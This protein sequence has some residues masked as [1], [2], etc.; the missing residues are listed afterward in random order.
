M[1]WV[2]DN[3]PT[4]SELQNGGTT[5]PFVGR[6]ASQV[7]DPSCYVC[8]ADYKH[9]PTTGRPRRCTTTFPV[10]GSGGEYHQSRSSLD[11]TVVYLFHLRLRI[12]SGSPVVFLVCDVHVLCACCRSCCSQDQSS[13]RS[14]VSRVPPTLDWALPGKQTCVCLRLLGGQG[15]LYLVR[16]RWS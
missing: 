12:Y 16:S 7:I 8:P 13:S 9:D 4:T 6:W 11:V 3:G 10:P 1:I 14:M 2:A 5:G 15:G